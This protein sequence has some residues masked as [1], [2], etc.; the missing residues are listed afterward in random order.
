MASITQLVEQ[1]DLSVLDSLKTMN[2]EFNMRFMLN[3]PTH[4]NLWKNISKI[5]MDRADAVLG[6]AVYG[7]ELGNEPS[8]C[9]LHE[10]C[11]DGSIDTL[12][13]IYDNVFELFAS[14][15]SSRSII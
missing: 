1:G 8:A 7:Y 9:E 15:H 2:K 11:R 12:Q 10:P 5:V 4:Y 14:M 6:R 3:L 13:C